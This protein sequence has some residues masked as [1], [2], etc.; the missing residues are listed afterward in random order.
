M[1]SGDE[2]KN[3]LGSCYGNRALIP[4]EDNR[5]QDYSS[6]EVSDRLSLKLS[7]DKES[8]YDYKTTKI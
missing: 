5:R 1:C 4:E 7:C 6:Q 3:V 2:T 8:K